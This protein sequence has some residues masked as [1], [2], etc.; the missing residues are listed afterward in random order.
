MNS[1]EFIIAPQVRIFYELRIA[2]Q[3]RISSTRFKAAPKLPLLCSTAIR[4]THFLQRFFALRA[5]PTG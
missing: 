2:P 3:V 4:H 1:Y 5:V